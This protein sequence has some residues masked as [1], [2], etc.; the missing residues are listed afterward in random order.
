MCINILHCVRTHTYIL[1]ATV[2]GAA[3]FVI[4][5]ETGRRAFY[6]LAGSREIW[7]GG[8]VSVFSV[9]HSHAHERTHI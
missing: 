5:R 4:N 9:I 3:A 1:Y 8:E 6:R 2:M 7:V